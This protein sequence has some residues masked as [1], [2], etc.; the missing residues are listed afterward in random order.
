[1]PNALLAGIKGGAKLKKSSDRKLPPPKQAPGAAGGKAGGMGGMMGGMNLAA[2]A[3]QRAQ[4]RRERAAAGNLRQV[5]VKRRS[6]PKK[7]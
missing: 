5:E 1:M 3:A 6:G 4:A 2:I 7:N